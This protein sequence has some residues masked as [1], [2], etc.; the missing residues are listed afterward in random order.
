MHVDTQ[1]VCLMIQTMH[2]QKR[3]NV[4]LIAEALLLLP[5][6]LEGVAI[7]GKDV[8]DGFVVCHHLSMLAYQ[9]KPLPVLS[10]QVWRDAFVAKSRVLVIPAPHSTLV[11]KSCC[12][13]AC[14]LTSRMTPDKHDQQLFQMNMHELLPRSPKN[15]A[16]TCARLSQHDKRTHKKSRH[17]HVRSSMISPQTYDDCDDET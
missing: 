11:I 9:G 4:V 3:R 15:K 17:Q 8:N 5:T 1:A 10:P 6:L 7:F 14:H 12:H 13:F 16:A 2:C